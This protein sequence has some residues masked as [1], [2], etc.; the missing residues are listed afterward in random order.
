M[1]EYMNRGPYATGVNHA[2]L[3]R[4]NATAYASWLTRTE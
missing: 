4:E 2:E 1:R 3:S